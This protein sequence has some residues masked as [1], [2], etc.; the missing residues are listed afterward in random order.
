[1]EALMTVRDKETHL[2][3]QVPDKGDQ[4]GNYL[5]STCSAMYCY[6]MAKGV[7]IGVLD[8]AYE[9]EDY[10]DSFYAIKKKFW[11]YFF[12]RI[13]WIPII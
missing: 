6:A 8:K 10:L 3:F 12:N 13:S 2:W 1:M 7:R 9:K 4:E 5:E 11:Q